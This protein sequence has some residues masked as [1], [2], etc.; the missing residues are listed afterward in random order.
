[1]RWCRRVSTIVVVCAV[2]TV[3]RAQTAG[4][5]VSTVKPTP[6]AN[7]GRTHINYPAGGDFSASNV[8]LLGL[9]AWAFDLPEKRIL[10]GPDWMSSRR[11]DLQA[12]TD[13]ATDASMRA[14][15]GEDAHAAKRRLVQVLL[16]ER[17]ALKAHH[18]TQTLGALDL[19][20]D[21]K[22]RLVESTAAGRTWNMGRTYLRGYGLTADVLAEELS[23]VAGRVVVDRTGLTGRYDVALEWAPD[24]G[25]AA[26]NS[27]APAFLRALPEQLGLKLVPAKE[28]LDVL[29]IDAVA[30]PSAN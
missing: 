24:D 3:C 5:E 7:D 6:A 14:M 15:S 23:R 4:F 21:G 10:N 17:F 27:N 2:L 1:M 8:T 9:V 18:E 22:P 13:A 29:L 16:Q 26:A 25:S 28:P 19:L 11:F 30:E 12:K 20:V